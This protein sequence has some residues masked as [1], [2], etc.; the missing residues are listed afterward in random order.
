MTVDGE[1][2]LLLE[3]VARR[4]RAPLSSV[5]HWVRLGRLASIRPGRRRLV[6]RDELERFLAQQSEPDANNGRIAR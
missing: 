5:R 1:E 3:E 4:C 2:L 6:R